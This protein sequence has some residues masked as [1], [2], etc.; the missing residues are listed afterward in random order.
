[1]KENKNG[2]YNDEKGRRWSQEL[3][4]YHGHKHWHVIVF[5]S[6]EEQSVQRTF[7]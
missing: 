4:L 3:V 5:G 6:N 2:T 7:K 1:M